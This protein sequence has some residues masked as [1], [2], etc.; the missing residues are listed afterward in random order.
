[1]KRA[2]G[3]VGAALVY[4]GLAL[5][6]LYPAW[7]DLDHGV[8]GDWRHP[9]TLSNHWL[10]RWVVE[11]L[12]AGE[13]IVHNDR[14]YVPIGDA[15]WLAGNGSDAVPSILLAWLPW[16]G[17]VTLWVVLA[18][19]LN[20]MAGLL[21][22]W[23]F[24]ASLAASLAAG[25]ALCVFP[26]VDAELSGGRFA[27]MPI[28]QVG[29]F[30]VAWHTLLEHAPEAGSWRPDRGTLARALVAAALFALAAFSYWYHG[31]WA[32]LLGVCW[33]AWRPRW[34]ALVPFV[35]AALLGVVPFLAIFLAHWAEIPGVGEDTFPH[36]VACQASL[37]PWFPFFGRPGFWG[38]IVTPTVLLVGLVAALWPGGRLGWGG[39]GALLAAALFWLLCL[40]PYPSWMGGASDGVPGPFWVYG[41]G[42]PLRR[43]WW[44]Y[45]HV[46][47]FTLALV[48]V[49]A[50]GLDRVF[51]AVARFSE[52]RLRPWIP[53]VAGLAVTLTLPVDLEA[54]QGMIAAPSSRWSPPEA[55]RAIAALPGDVLL[56]L[57][58]TPER[59][60]GQQTL[61]YQW[62]HGKRLLNGHAMWVDRVRPTAWES[63]VEADPFL[64]ALRSVERGEAVAVPPVLSGVRAV[65]LRLIVVNEEYFP[66]TLAP[67]VTTYRTTLTA[68]FGPPAVDADGVTAWDVDTVVAS[69]PVDVPASALPALAD[70]EGGKVPD[71]GRLSPKGWALL[72]R[73]VPP[74]A[75]TEQER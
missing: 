35:P 24:G 60:T 1:M 12:L 53:I 5:Y 6:Q 14:Y 48:P 40:G 20:G 18:L 29:F 3:L 57:P 26:Y 72:S 51:A 46:V 4:L 22:A 66:G 37:P 27:Q 19:V 13:S 31:L 44:P 34:R 16:P 64:H 70:T 8:V 59:V 47:G 58:L 50:V 41:L 45:R 38:P 62:I 33:F 49:A 15:P 23:R 69:G 32:A 68:L 63:F 74:R 54:R 67:L 52:P 55:Y 10:Y 43:F 7:W 11:R 75:I 25:A 56:E 28:Y 36:P 21:L 9:D 30:L 71:Y 17:S 65:G 42:G 2:A 39:R 61:S 73:D